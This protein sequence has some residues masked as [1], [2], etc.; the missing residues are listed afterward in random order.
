MEAI[1]KNNT[2]YLCTKKHR[3]IVREQREN[4]GNF[5]AF[6]IKAREVDVE[7]DKYCRKLSVINKKYVLKLFVILKVH[8]H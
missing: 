4:T 2:C 6:T 3:E 8:L 7:Q 5:H 1:Y